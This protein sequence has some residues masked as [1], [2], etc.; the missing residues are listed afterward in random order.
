MSFFGVQHA[1]GQFCMGSINLI[2]LCTVHALSSALSINTATPNHCSKRKLKQKFYEK[3]WKLP[4]SNPGLL[5]VRRIRFN[6][7]MQ[8]PPIQMM[9]LPNKLSKSA[10]KTIFRSIDNKEVNILALNLKRV[11]HLAPHAS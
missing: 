8:P 10:S 5:G 9:T 1:T 4:D 3:I 2:K 11:C 6:Y 7:P